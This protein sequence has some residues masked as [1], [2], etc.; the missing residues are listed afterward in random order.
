MRDQE[1]YQLSVLP[2]PG[3]DAELAFSSSRMAAVAASM[4]AWWAALA[5]LRTLRR[6]RM[7]AVSMRMLRVARLPMLV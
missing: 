4:M 7:A 1:A 3:A 5:G 6:V 2:G